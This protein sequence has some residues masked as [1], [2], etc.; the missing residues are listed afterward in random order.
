MISTSKTHPK[1]CLSLV[2]KQK[3][4]FQSQGLMLTIAAPPSYLARLQRAAPRHG[5]GL[6]EGLLQ[7]V[8]LAYP[9]CTALL[10]LWA[11]SINYKQSHLGGWQAPLICPKLDCIT[12]CSQITALGIRGLKHPPPFLHPLIGPSPLTHTHFHVAS[13]GNMRVSCVAVAN[14]SSCSFSLPHQKKKKK[15]QTMVFKKETKCIF[16]DKNETEP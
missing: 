2:L 14:N 11:Q 13:S 12:V 8:P 10:G 4:G 7:G 9:E 6:Q 3:E 16:S 15:K 1:C 5:R